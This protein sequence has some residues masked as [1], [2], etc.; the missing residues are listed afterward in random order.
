MNTRVEPA[1]DAGYVATSFQ[2]S[3]SK[4][5]N[6]QALAS[7]RR[8][9]SWAFSLSPLDIEGRRD[10]ERRTLVTAAAYFPDCRETEAHGNA[11]QRPAAATSSTLGPDFRA[12]ARASSP[13]R[14][15]S[16]PFTRLVQPLKAAPRSGHGRLPKA[17]RVH[18]CEAWPRAP[19]R[20]VW[21]SPFQPALALPH[22]RTPHEAPLTGQD[23]IRIS[24]VLRAGIG[25]HSQVREWEIET[26]VVMAGKSAKR[27]F[28]LDVPAIHVLLLQR[29]RKT[30]MPATGAGMTS[31][32]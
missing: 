7:P 27:V 2:N 21:V 32:W 14:Q 4:D 6:S 5:S 13:S 18:A 23:A 12:Q 26:S 31:S 11:S 29:K 22:F 17:P 1:Y 20:P 16:P 24:E 28:A 3:D 10:A 25:I 9:A 19:H 8:R 30:W 15:V